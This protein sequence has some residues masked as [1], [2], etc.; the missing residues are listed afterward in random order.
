MVSTKE[1]P[2]A[3]DGMERAEPGEP[4]FTLRAHDP[5]A[6][7]LVHEWVSRKRDLILKGDL[8]EEKRNIELI[9]CREAEEIAFAM[10]DWHD[11]LSPTPDDPEDH[12]EPVKAYSGNVR[13]PA[14]AIAKERHDAHKGAATRLHNSAAEIS[15]AAEMLEPY[16]WAAERAEITG[17]R[18]RL[19][20]LGIDVA[21]KRA[22]YHVTDEDRE[23]ASEQG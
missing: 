5:L 10:R 2:G 3:F 21:P 18:D 12:P 4:V 9:Q 14:E 16:G 11:G 7:A 1:S 20:A 19:T 22:S 13:D 6:A 15:D 23:K 17:L 8:T